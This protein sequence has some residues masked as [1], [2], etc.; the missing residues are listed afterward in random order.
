MA[1]VYYLLGGK[2][3]NDLEMAT[4]CEPSFEIAN[5][6]ISE[7]VEEG[8]T[9]EEKRKRISDTIH[10]YDNFTDDDFMALGECF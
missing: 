1:F 4:Y 2:N 7:F 8:M 3:V 9:E 10:M 5:E 6:V